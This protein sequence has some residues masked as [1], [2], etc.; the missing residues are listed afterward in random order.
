[1]PLPILLQFSRPVAAEPSTDL[2]A[3]DY[4]SGAAE[5]AGWA[6]GPSVAGYATDEMAIS[7]VAG[8]GPSG[9][10]VYRYTYTTQAH[11]SGQ[12]DFGWGE[13]FTGAPFAYG[14]VVYVRFRYRINSGAVFRFYRTEEGDLSALGR[15]KFII[16]NNSSSTET[17]RAILDLQ[18]NRDMGSGQSTNW[19]LGKGAGVDAVQT[20]DAALDSNWHSVQMRLR[21]SSAFGVSD[22]GWDVWVDNAVEGSP[23]I[24]QSNIAMYAD[25]SPGQ[26]AFG[27]YQNNGLYSDGVLVI[28]QTGFAI[29]DAFTAGWT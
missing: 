22:G 15:L 12:F 19:R 26:I 1:M 8:V 16:F 21:Y 13:T 5:A 6:G 14:D 10:D 20:T 7:R 4:S 25:V 18:M 23:S 27:A 3:M 11:P 17:S 9:A 2:F 28:D 24:T 29:S